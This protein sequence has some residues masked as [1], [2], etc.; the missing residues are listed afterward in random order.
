MV[1]QFKRM[2]LIITVAYSNYYYR[3]LDEVWS[4]NNEDF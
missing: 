3:I 1:V 4:K 2:L